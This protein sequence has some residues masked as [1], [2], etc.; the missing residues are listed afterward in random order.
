MA[1]FADSTREGGFAG[2]AG[3]GMSSSGGTSSGNTSSGGGLANSSREGGF[4]GAAGARMS[5]GGGNARDGNIGGGNVG[6]GGGL[7][8]LSARLGDLP[9]ASARSAG[10]SAV[11]AN[12]LGQAIANPSRLGSIPGGGISGLKGSLA[13]EQAITNMEAAR[14]I[15]AKV[16]GPSPMSVYGKEF[17]F[18]PQEFETAIRSD[19]LAGLNPFSKALPG[20]SYDELTSMQK[21]VQKTGAV[22]NGTQYSPQQLQNALA[23]IQGGFSAG[24]PAATPDIN[25]VRGLNIPSAPA[26]VSA[27]PT[28]DF[29]GLSALGQDLAAVSATPTEDFRDFS[30]V[31]KAFADAQ[32]L[33]SLN[34]ILNYGM[35]TTGTV[36]DLPGVP[37]GPTRVHAGVDIAAPTGTTVTPSMPGTVINTGTATGYG[38]YA[39]VMDIYGNVQRYAMHTT[40]SLN[41]NVGSYVAPGD[42]I[43]TVGKQIPGTFEHLHFENISPSDLAYGPLSRQYT[44]VLSGNTSPAGFIGSTKSPVGAGLQSSTRDLVSALGLHTGMQ[45]SAGTSPVAPTENVNY[46]GS[47]PAI[48]ASAAPTSDFRNPSTSSALASAIPTSDFRGPP[49][50]A[51]LAALGKDTVA[52]PSTTQSTTAPVTSVAAVPPPK[53]FFARLLNDFYSA[54]RENG[55]TQVASAQNLLPPPYSKDETTEPT[56]PA[57][58]GLNWNFQVGPAYVAPPTRDL[59]AQYQNLFSQPA[60]K[61]T[62]LGSLLPNV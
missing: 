22:V 36:Q 21:A 54:G 26:R 44:N 13:Q 37:R 9:A 55:N 10:M 32:N 51:A 4:A 8:G 39:D 49:T 23:G 60:P 5:S 11:Q 61:S 48:L 41:T 18:T 58:T 46:A 42:I 33:A 2:A 38:P 1:G 14:R 62:G 59:Y 24:L 43:G 15:A 17:N 25:T 16:A 27:A 7:A 30:P 31:A 6:G 57:T 3:A 29:R 20:L 40:G 12:A 35:P 47:T 19:Y 52:A 34:D 28:S 56:T 45:I 50:S 53:N